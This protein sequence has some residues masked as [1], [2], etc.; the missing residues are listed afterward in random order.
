MPIDDSGTFPA[1]QH[2]VVEG[3]HVSD[4]IDVHQHGV[5]DD[6]LTGHG[7]VNRQTAEFVHF[8][9]D[10][11]FGALDQRQR[12][13]VRSHLVQCLEGVEEA[14]DVPVVACAHVILRHE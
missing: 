5:D 9:L 7:D 14:I 12:D 11:G 10:A 8:Q 1:A 4:R 3:A 6:L 13:L 2:G